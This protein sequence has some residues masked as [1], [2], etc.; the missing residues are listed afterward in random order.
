[1]GVMGIHTPIK[2]LLSDIVVSY[3]LE[4]TVT[5]IEDRVQCGGIDSKVSEVES[6]DVVLHFHRVGHADIYLSCGP[7][8]NLA[9][10]QSERMFRGLLLAV[11]VVQ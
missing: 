8:N 9:E 10:I 3:V 5:Y 1:M 11:G 6:R 2:F 4:V 7:L